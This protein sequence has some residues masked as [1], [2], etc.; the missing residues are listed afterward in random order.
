MFWQL[1]DDLVSGEHSR[2]QRED[3]SDDG[4][5]CNFRMS[6]ITVVDGTH[7]SISDHLFVSYLHSECTLSVHGNPDK[8]SVLYR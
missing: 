8:Y 3:R 7:T 2:I 1:Y 6:S 4:A 5:D